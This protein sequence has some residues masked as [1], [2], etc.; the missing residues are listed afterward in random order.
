MRMTNEEIRERA[1]VEP[2][3]GDLA[4]G[5]YAASFFSW[6]FICGLVDGLN[7]RG[8]SR[9]PGQMQRQLQRIE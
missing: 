3:I 9:I 8:A 6:R 5:F 2:I 4:P 1:A 7:E